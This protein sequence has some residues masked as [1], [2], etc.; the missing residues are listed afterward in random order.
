MALD[1]TYLFVFDPFF[2]IEFQIYYKENIA[3]I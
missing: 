3:N 2:I 1:M